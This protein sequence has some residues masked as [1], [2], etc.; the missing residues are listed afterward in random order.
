MS[1]YPRVRCDLCVPPRVLCLAKHFLLESRLFVAVAEA[2]PPQKSWVWSLSI[3][4][5]FRRVFAAQL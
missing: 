1:L 4:N 5:R 3:A 2:L